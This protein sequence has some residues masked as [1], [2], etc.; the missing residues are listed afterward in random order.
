MKSS[1]E[2]QLAE[3]KR[4]FYWREDILPR[5]WRP[6]CQ[7]AGAEVE[8]V[9]LPLECKESYTLHTQSLLPGT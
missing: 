9:M 5:R 8:Q 7:G 4:K 6:S 2:E 3:E 1:G